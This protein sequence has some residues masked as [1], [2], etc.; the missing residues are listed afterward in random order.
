MKAVYL[1]GVKIE[2]ILYVSTKEEE[3]YEYEYEYEGS[4]VQPRVFPPLTD[5]LSSVPVA[6]STRIGRDFSGIGWLH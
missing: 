5:N 3:E 6:H 2:D 4:S 1:E